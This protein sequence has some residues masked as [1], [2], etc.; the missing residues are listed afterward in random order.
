MHRPAVVRPLRV[1][2]EDGVGD[3]AE[4]LLGDADRGER[5]AAVLAVDDDPVE[6]REE[7][8]PERG[9][10]RRAARQKVVR[11]E[12][13]GEMRAEEARVEL[14]RG[15]PLHVQDVRVEPAERGEAERVLRRLERNAAAASGRRRAT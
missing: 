3:D 6:A 10:V 14:R 5:V 13:R 2:R 8:Q 12:H 7:L 11:G 15:E 9:L 1:A 4:L